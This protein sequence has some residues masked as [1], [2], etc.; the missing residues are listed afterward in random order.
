MHAA[1]APNRFTVERFGREREPVVVIDGFSGGIDALEAEGRRADYA[2]Q[3][4]YPGLRA[5]ADPAYLETR[6]DFLIQI[7]AE[8]FA[9]EQAIVQTCDFSIVSRTPDALMAPQRIPHYDHTSPAVVALLHYTQGPETGGTA[10]FRQRRTGFETVTPNRLEI[11][12]AARMADAAEHG[13]PP[14]G[15]IGGETECYDRIGAVEARR[16]RAVL[17]RAR[18]LHSGIIPQAPDPARARSCGRMTINSFLVGKALD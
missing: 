16:D 18:T 7:L 15:Y 13:P 3:R 14:A 6:L 4:M 2:E 5:P 17:Y 9:I 10:F 1:A 8:V 11:Y 12:K